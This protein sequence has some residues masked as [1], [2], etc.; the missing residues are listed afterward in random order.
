MAKRT[1]ITWKEALKI[2]HAQTRKKLAPMLKAMMEVYKERNYEE[3][4]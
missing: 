2:A 4:Y 1:E 3:R